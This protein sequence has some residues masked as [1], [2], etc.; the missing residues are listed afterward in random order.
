KGVVASAAKNFHTAL[1]LTRL[2]NDRKAREALYTLQAKR[3]PDHGLPASIVRLELARTH[4]RNGR[5]PE[6]RETLARIKIK[7]DPKR[8]EPGTHRQN[9]IASHREFLLG[10]AANAELDREKAVKHF[11]KA[12]THGGVALA[13]QARYEQARSLELGGHWSKAREIYQ[14]LAGNAQAEGIR[15]AAGISLPRLDALGQTPLPK[16]DGAITQL[17]D[18]RETRGDWYLGYGA[19]C[20][21][22]ASVIHGGSS[23]KLQLA[24][25]TSDP[26]QRGARWTSARDSADPTA[27]WSPR[28]R[29]RVAAN[30]DDRGGQYPIGAGPDLLIGTAIPKGQHILSLYFANDSRY[31]E[32]SRR[33]TIEMRTGKELLALAEARDFGGGVYKRFLVTGPRKLQI[34][35]RRDA[36]LNTLLQGAFLDPVP[37]LSPSPLQPATAADPDQGT[38]GKYARR[39]T[40]RPANLARPAALVAFANSLAGKRKPSL[41]DRRYQSYQ[42]LLAA[43]RPRTA[44]R[45]FKAFAKTVAKERALAIVRELGKQLPQTPSSASCQPRDWPDGTHPLDILNKRWL[46]RYLVTPADPQRTKT[47][48]GLLGDPGPHVT[49]YARKQALL[50]LDRHAPKRL[51]ASILL[52]AAAGSEKA[53]DEPQTAVFL[54]RALAAKPTPYTELRASTRLLDIAPQ[55]K[56]PVAEIR[57]LYAR[58]LVLAKQQK[59]KHLLPIVHLHA[60][61]AFAAQGEYEEALA[62]LDHAPPKLA[63]SFAKSYQRKLDEKLKGK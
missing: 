39:L 11:A 47:L 19:E 53:R 24:L 43:G 60:A 61:M 42:L 35:L 21:Q 26:K 25:S 9:A 37:T 28:N 32:A 62:L 41:A 5:F 14:E 30:F 31:Y 50:L 20:S 18:D 51:S 27:P 58:I 6:A 29:W 46:D 33:Y 16:S 12:A 7:R 22:F 23:I 40:R 36:S 56:M 1:V 45:A 34:C 59:A 17:P 3:S 13:E 57:A 54:R 10:M 55:A 48:L 8:P 49:P 52:A 2:P 4:L 63:D 38:Y 15:R 44:Q